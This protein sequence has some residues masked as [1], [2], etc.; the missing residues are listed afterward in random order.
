MQG[1][2][3]NRRRQRQTNQNHGLVP[4]PP[5]GTLG[6]VTCAQVAGST[7][8]RKKMCSSMA[9]KTI[10]TFLSQRMGHLWVGHRDAKQWMCSSTPMADAKLYP[11]DL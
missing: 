8:R 7:K 4:S 5:K 11:P 2:E 3:A 1:R 6:Y 10:G 9:Y